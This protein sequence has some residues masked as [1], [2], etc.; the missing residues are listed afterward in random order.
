M[1][2]IDGGARD[3]RHRH[4]QKEA[5][6]RRVLL[7]LVAAAAV[8][9]SMFTLAPATS[10]EEGTGQVTLAGSGVLRA[11]GTGF[12]HLRGAMD[13]R[14]SAQAGVLV[15]HD[16]GGNALIDVEGYG[17][18]VELPDGGV[19]YYGFH[20]SAHIRGR[21][22]QLDLLAKG[23]RFRAIGKGVAF[24]AGRGWYSVNGFP[25]QPWSDAGATVE[26]SD[27]SSPD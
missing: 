19:A 6:M 26:L 10:A 23:I 9:A 12:A 2:N 24:L 27:E 5:D 1:L 8:G 13:F 22:V 21:D 17:Q 14:G 15:V 11:A 18:R 4:S 25:P 7:I 3:S 20:G 16:H